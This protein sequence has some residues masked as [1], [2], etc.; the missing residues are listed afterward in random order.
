MAPIASE[1]VLDHGAK[2]N[3]K[4]HDRLLHSLVRAAG[5]GHW[6]QLCYMIEQPSAYL[7][8]DQCGFHALAVAINKA[9]SPGQITWENFLRL[10]ETLAWTCFSRES[11][12]RLDRWTTNT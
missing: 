3:Y 8:N 9:A 2:L 12:R 7:N 10:H 1:H 4:Y 6:I 5:E 11:A